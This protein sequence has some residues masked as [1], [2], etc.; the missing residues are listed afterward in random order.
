[1]LIRN[2][3]EC[4]ILSQ[5]VFKIFIVDFVSKYSPVIKKGIKSLFYWDFIPLFLVLLKEIII[6][7]HC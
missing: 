6:F 7:Q 2:P 1:M 3:D 5:N 4:G